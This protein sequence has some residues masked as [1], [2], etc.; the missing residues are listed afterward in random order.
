MTAKNVVKDYARHVQ[1]VLE[2]DD[3]Q[4]LV[5]LE[6]ATGQHQAQREA[7][8]HRAYREAVKATLVERIKRTA[9]KAG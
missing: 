4:V 6:V 7:G 9:R 3:N 5:H 8:D 1:E 2:A